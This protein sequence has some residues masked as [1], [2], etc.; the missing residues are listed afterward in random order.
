MLDAYRLPMTPDTL[1]NLILLS[2]GMA[3]VSTALHIEFRMR[4]TSMIQHDTARNHDIFLW[5]ELRDL[6]DMGACYG[7]RGGG[8]GGN[9]LSDMDD[10]M[11]RLS[12][13]SLADQEPDQ[14]NSPSAR[15]RR[16]RRQLRR[17]TAVYRNVYIITHPGFIPYLADM[18]GLDFGS[19]RA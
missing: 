9:S 18:R 19:G 7:G 11:T 5:R 13:V 2:P 4:Y 16:V 12:G 8:D 10:L 6:G 3:C 15:A 14:G 1:P 17:F